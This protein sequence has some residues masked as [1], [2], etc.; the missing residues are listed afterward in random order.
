LPTALAILRALR[1]LGA[2]E[3]PRAWLSAVFPT[4]EEEG[5]GGGGG[6]GG[7]DN[8]PSS[9]SSSVAAGLGLVYYSPEQAAEAVALLGRLARGASLRPPAGWARR[10]L[11][12][13]L[14]GGGGAGGE[15]AVAAARLLPTPLLASFMAGAAALDVVPEP[16]QADALVE[17][18][19]RRVLMATVGVGVE[20]KGR[21]GRGQRRQR[22][23]S[24]A[25]P[26][27]QAQ[28]RDVQR[29]L[30]AWAY[31]PSHPHG[32]WQWAAVR[33]AGRAAAAAVEERA[34]GGAGAGAGGAGA[35]APTAPPSG[36]EEA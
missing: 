29:A 15:G 9:S 35:R 13:A 7:S 18:V 24:L 30:S 23:A 6:G 20:E 4:V 34:G 16:A 33:E 28:L 22:R 21:S 12:K 3:A 27:T 5:S 31:R 2:K 14:G 36:D 32:K 1:A 25:S 17:E 11:D 8:A 19:G 10:A 26:P